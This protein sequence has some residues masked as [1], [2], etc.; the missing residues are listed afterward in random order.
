MHAHPIALAS[1]PHITQ[2]IPSALFYDILGG[3][4]ISVSRYTYMVCSVLKAPRHSED[5]F[6]IDVPLSPP[7]P[8]YPHPRK[9]GQLLDNSRLTKSTA[10]HKGNE[11][12]VRLET[13]SVGM[14]PSCNNALLSV[15]KV[16]SFEWTSLLYCSIKDPW[17]DSMDG[18]SPSEFQLEPCWEVS[19]LPNQAIQDSKWLLRLTSKKRWSQ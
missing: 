4:C 2:Q 5:L 3:H 12:S 14:E 6:T 15:S 13:L 10:S 8:R 17:A 7:P 16:L 18:L 1:P 11:Y 19:S 9:L